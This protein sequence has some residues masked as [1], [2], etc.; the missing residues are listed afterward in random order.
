[1]DFIDA[2]PKCEGYSVILVVVDRFTKYAHF[3]SLKHPYTASLVAQ[4]FFSTVVKLHGLPKAIV[5]DRDKVFTSSFWK[6]LFKI[7]DTKL[8]L[9]LAYHAQNDGH[10]TRTLSTPV[11]VCLAYA[12]CGQST[13]M[14]TFHKSST[15][16]DRPYCSLEK[17]LMTQHPA[18]LSDPQTATQF[19]S[20]YSH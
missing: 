3:L 15:A 8:C 9:S 6:E 12:S 13:Y 2:L 19:L 1:M 4:A 18:R 16:L 17:G 5:S 10:T 14:A 20:Q 11:H 7:M